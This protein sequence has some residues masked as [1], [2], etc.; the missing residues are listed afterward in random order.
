MKKI[1]LEIKSVIDQLEGESHKIELTTEA[2]LYEKNGSIYLVYFESEV[3]GMEGCKTMLKI[4]K[5]LITMTRFGQSN[6][7]IVFDK[8]QQTSSVY[9]T[10]YGAFDMLVTTEILSVDFDLEKGTG[11]LLLEYQMVLE[12]VSASR[13]RLELKIRS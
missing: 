4:D 9:H 10:P 11:E 2:D 7:K 6:S 13:N 1:I 5:E 8:S 12:Q 3:S